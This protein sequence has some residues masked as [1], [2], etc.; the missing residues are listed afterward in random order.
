MKSQRV[1][2]YFD[3]DCR[4][5]V[6]AQT[7]NF[8]FLDQANQKKVF[9]TGKRKNGNH[10]GILHIQISLSLKF[11]LQQTI[12]IFWNKFPKKWKLSV[13]NKTYKEHH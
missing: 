9:S 6:S 3:H 2:K 1:S 12:L 11:Q 5:Q 10:Y 7:N 13:K 8:K 4:Y